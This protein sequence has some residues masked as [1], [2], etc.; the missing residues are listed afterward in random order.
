VAAKQAV[1]Y[2]T[3]LPNTKTTIQQTLRL[4]GY[5]TAMFG[6]SHEVPIWEQSPAGPFDRWPTG[7]GFNYFYGF[8]GGETNQYFPALYKK[9]VPRQRKADDQLGDGGGDAPVLVGIG[10]P[11]IDVGHARGPVVGDPVHGVAAEA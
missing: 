8:I 11:V 7:T 3:M 9:R 6:K 1:G 2:S 5:A 4:N 10:V